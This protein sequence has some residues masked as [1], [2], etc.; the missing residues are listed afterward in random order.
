MDTSELRNLRIYLHIYPFP[1]PLSMEFS[2]LRCYPY[3][4]KGSG[5]RTRR[6]IMPTKR[7]IL[8][9]NSRLLLEIF[10]RVIDKAEHLEVVQEIFSHEELPSAIERFDPEWVITS[11]PMQNHMSDWIK[12]DNAEYPSLRFIFLSPENNRITMKWQTSSE[13]DI[14]NLSVKEFIT[15]LEKDLQHI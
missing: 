2:A 11:L 5:R 10:H 8:A 14:S 7:I 12:A 15:I 9:N 3:K 13:E 4:R 1:V 6:E